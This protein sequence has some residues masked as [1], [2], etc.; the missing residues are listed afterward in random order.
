MEKIVGQGS[1]LKSAPV[2][3]IV[4]VAFG[5]NIDVARKVLRHIMGDAA[6]DFRSR[7]ADEAARKES[8]HRAEM[9]RLG[10]SEVRAGTVDSGLNVFRH[11]FPKGVPA[12]EMSGLPADLL[13]IGLQLCDVYALRDEQ[14]GKAFLKFVFEPG[15]PAAKYSADLC[16]RVDEY[17]G[18]AAKFV[19]VWDNRDTAAETIT[20]NVI[21]GN[22][23]RDNGAD[24]RL[25][26][27][28]GFGFELRAL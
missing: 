21:P 5:Q 8:V 27:V 22:G 26:I 1:A 12:S 10:R 7:E 17:L 18:R 23:G 24:Y 9:I 19:H 15:M 25:R 6:S 2:A 13:R 4:S 16:R 20:V 3:L 28:E 14:T 11:V